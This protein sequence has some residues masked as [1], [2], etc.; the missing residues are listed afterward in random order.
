MDLEV[1]G[2]TESPIHDASIRAEC[3]L[4]DFA[5]SAGVP[6]QCGKTTTKSI[7]E[8]VQLVSFRIKDTTGFPPN[9]R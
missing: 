5:K 4:P 8:S 7:D 6:T 9:L 3:L 2:G 1:N